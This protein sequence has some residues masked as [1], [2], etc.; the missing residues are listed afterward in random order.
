MRILLIPNISSKD[1]A[2]DSVGLSM[3]NWIT[4]AVEKDEVFGWLH[5]LSKH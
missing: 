2:T 4:E 3:S 1:L 5:Q